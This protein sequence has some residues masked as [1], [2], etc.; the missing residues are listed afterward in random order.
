MMARSSNVATTVLSGRKEAEQTAISTIRKQTIFAYKQIKRTWHAHVKSGME[1]WSPLGAGL[2]LR[3]ETSSGAVNDMS[4]ANRGE[5]SQSIDSPDQWIKLVRKLRWIGLQR[6]AELL[7]KALAM[8][9]PC[10]ADR[11]GPL[12]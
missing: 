8:L 3:P 9:A 11:R 12:K 6:D 7:Q 5:D 1:V 2:M 4:R 10:D